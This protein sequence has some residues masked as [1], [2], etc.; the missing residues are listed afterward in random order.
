MLEDLPLDV[1]IEILKYVHPNE[2]FKNVSL[3]S[4]YWY[5]VVNRGIF[6]RE[7]RIHILKSRR[8][9]NSLRTFLYKAG[10]LSFFAKFIGIY[11]Y[12]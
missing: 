8:S 1:H 6:W 9:M 7:I 5:S 12:T 2:R 10:F 4:K 11:I 3:V